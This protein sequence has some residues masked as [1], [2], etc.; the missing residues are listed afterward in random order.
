MSDKDVLC[1]MIMR[2]KKERALTLIFYFVR[3]F[4]NKEDKTA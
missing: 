3:N 4:I 1:N 2:I